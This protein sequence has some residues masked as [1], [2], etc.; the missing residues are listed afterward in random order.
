MKKLKLFNI[1]VNLKLNE[2]D[3]KKT[4]DYIKK[5]NEKYLKLENEFN[6]LRN[7]LISNY[8]TLI[9]NKLYYNEIDNIYKF[10]IIDLLIY[11][12][13]MIE[14]SNIYNINIKLDN[15]YNKSNDYNLN[16]KENDL[17]LLKDLL[18]K[19]NINNKYN[20]NENYLNYLHYYLIIILENINYYEIYNL[21]DYLEILK[22]IDLI[23]NNKCIFI[24]IFENNKKIEI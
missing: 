21:N 8:E 4:Y 13:E 22:R 6:N 9:I 18:I 24:N 5:E 2:N 11:I 7:K 3:I 19:E 12:N 17:K 10:I 20:F 14:K 23:L 1:N 15:L 16:Y